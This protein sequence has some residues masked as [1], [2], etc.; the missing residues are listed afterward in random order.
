MNLPGKITLVRLILVPGFIF[1][2]YFG[3]W[4]GK[5][6]SFF[7]FLGASLSDALDGWLA[8]RRGEVTNWGKIIDPLADKIMVYG[9]L[10]SLIPLGLCPFWLPILW[11]GRDFLLDGL[12]MELAGRGK[13]LAASRW[14]KRKTLF[15]VGALYFAFLLL[16]LP[17][18]TV[19]QKGIK[20]IYIFLLALATL[21]TLGS[22]IHYWI[23]A[24]E[25]LG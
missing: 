9:A 15:Q 13:I 24:R 23:K 5:F 17:P 25:E 12:R 14:G 4:W 16:L 18:G 8:R 7:L 19:W 6:I 10:I 3:G 22:G 1:F 20:I 2:L 21:L 11:M